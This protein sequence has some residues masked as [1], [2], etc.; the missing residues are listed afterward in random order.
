[1]PDRPLA[2]RVCLVAGASRGVGRGIALGLAEAGASVIVTGRSSEAGAI[3]D[4]RRETV[5]ETARLVS[6]LGGKGYPYRCDHTSEREVDQLLAWALRRFGRIDCLV[7]SVWGGNEGYDG[8]RYPDGSRFG[9]PFWRRP[10][11]LLGR[12][13][14]TGL[15]AQVL[16]A[17]AFA[18]A[19]AAAKRGLMVFVTSDQDGAYL[20]DCWYDLAKSAISRFAFVAADDLQPFGVDV[21]AL[22][23]G[24]VR[25]ERVVDAGIADDATESPN[26]VGR[27]VAALLADDRRRL[28]RGR[29]VHSADL[30]RRYGVLDVD[31]R[32][33]ERFRLPEPANDPVTS[34]EQ[35]SP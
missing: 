7:G 31:G 28:P 5:E 15:Y 33:P 25:T 35:T 12:E 10:L 20:G 27:V 30:G 22:S 14:E 8:D 21:V 32:M 16:T 13:L 24:H 1:V 9:S 3:T 2:G 23:P 11:A 18:P 34:P 17:K 6:L 4:S 29:I 26:F 19:M